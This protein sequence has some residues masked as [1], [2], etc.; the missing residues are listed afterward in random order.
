[1]K[2]EDHDC[3]GAIMIDGEVVE[4][5]D[6]AVAMTPGGA[7]AVY[8]LATDEED[9]ALNSMPLRDFNLACVAADDAEP[10]PEPTPESPIPE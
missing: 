7:I 3:K 5:R 4:V 8:R 10:A 6:A 1:M 2:I 9:S